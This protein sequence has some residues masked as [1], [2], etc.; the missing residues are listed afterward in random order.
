VASAGFVALYL[1]KAFGRLDAPHVWQNFTV[2]LPLVLFWMWEVLHGLSRGVQWLLRPGQHA[3]PTWRS[4]GPRLVNAPIAVALVLIS[5]A[6]SGPLLAWARAID[7]RHRLTAVVDPDY[8]LG[9]ALPTAI[10]PDLLHDLDIVLRTYAG[11][12]GTVFD[13][14]NSPGYVYFLLGR[15]PGTR[16]NPVALAETP[17]AQRLLI[18]ELERSRPPVVIFDS[19]QMGL[20]SWDWITNN[21][22][23]YVLSQY[24]LQNWTP[25][26]RT[27]GNL[28]LVRRDLAVANRPAPP[29]NQ[30]PQLSDLYFSG[31][32][33][34][35]GSSAA[36]L[37]TSRTG[38]PLTLT[39]EP[40]GSR[41]VVKVTGWAI[42]P[43]TG[44]AATSVLVV[45]DQHRVIAAM[46]PTVH[47]PDVAASHGASAGGSGFQYGAA[48]LPGEHVGFY[49]LSA[50]GALH[51][52]TG[53]TNGAIEVTLL[54]GR[55]VPVA[56]SPAGSIDSETRTPV[57]LSTIT[58]PSG[59]TLTDY[60]LATA[61]SGSIPLGASSLALTDQPGQIYHDISAASPA[62]IGS[63]LT[64]P[65][66]SCPQWYGFDPAKPLYVVQQGGAPVTSITLSRSS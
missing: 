53:Q 57:T 28:I 48:V 26:L 20:P 41:E 18:G 59:V 44:Q 13:M 43:S 39:T 21:V 27:H 62:W 25:V 64:V 60:Q 61:S 52:L 8:R 66:A 14:T 15:H 51:P 4:V 45:N 34:S 37:P 32:V 54:D 42:D 7:T 23:H 5:L 31:P 56:A 46:A 36:Y 55:T 63:E 24:L 29:L 40:V 17:H 19:T 33:C 11:D 65:V 9:Y 2:A 10:D 22:R 35:W 16:F 47:R 50:D 30:P 12:D 38:T 58:V 1:E 6:S 49:L 3:R